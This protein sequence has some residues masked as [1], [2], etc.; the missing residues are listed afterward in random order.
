VAACGGQAFGRAWLK[1]FAA[2][3]GL[4]VSFQPALIQEEATAD[5]MK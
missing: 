4:E 3:V 2:T 1:A 5:R